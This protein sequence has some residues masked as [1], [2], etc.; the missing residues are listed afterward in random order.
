MISF[1]QEVSTWSCSILQEDNL[2]CDYV[3]IST[4]L[5][6][7]LKTVL[8]KDQEE[9]DRR[10]QEHFSTNKALS[11][12]V[13]CAAATGAALLSKIPLHKHISSQ[14][15]CLSSANCF[16]EGVAATSF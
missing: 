3:A 1:I 14:E 11:Q 2:N 7:H 12:A 16:T 5:G 15:V 10:L 6:E 13:S 4:S 9:V 8:I